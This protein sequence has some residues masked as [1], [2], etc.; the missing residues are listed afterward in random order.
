[1]MRMSDRGYKILKTI[2]E[3]PSISQREMAESLGLSVGKINYCVRAL[4]EKGWIKANNF[5]NS[6]NKIAYA[7]LLTPQGV[8]SRTHLAKS[9]LERKI[10]EYE[11]LHAEIEELKEDLGVEQ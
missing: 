4:I 8:A 7:Y 5:K 6:N 9:F 1:M 2:E 10:Q 11:R 3:S